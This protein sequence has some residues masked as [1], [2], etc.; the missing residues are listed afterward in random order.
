MEDTKAAGEKSEIEKQMD[1][2]ARASIPISIPLLR[3]RKLPEVFVV[4]RSGQG[5]L[6]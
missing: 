4:E 6:P 2:D 5:K 1:L 3:Q